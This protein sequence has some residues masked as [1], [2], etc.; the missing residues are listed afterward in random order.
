MGLLDLAERKGAEGDFK[1]AENYYKVTVT[2]INNN[3]VLVLAACF[4]S[5]D[6]GRRTT[7]L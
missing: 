2:I 1:E 3:T 5:A 7:I 4:H 6:I